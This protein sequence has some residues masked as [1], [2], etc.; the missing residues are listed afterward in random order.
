MSQLLRD[1]W[2]EA[3]ELA[4]ALVVEQLL[5]ADL[6]AQCRR[7]GLAWDADREVA[8]IDFLGRPYEIRSPTFDVVAGDRIAGDGSAADEVALVERILL[9]HYLNRADGTP[10]PGEW[11]AFAQIPGGDLYLRNFQARSADRI[12]RTFGDRPQALLDAAAPLGGEA[13]DFG[14]AAVVIQA[15]PRVRLLVVV[16]GGDDEFSATASVLFEA[17][18]THYLS[19]EDAIVMADRTATSLLRGRAR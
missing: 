2:R 16:H 18:A 17:N 11:I 8:K 5:T 3:W 4:L 9:L 19:T 15:L 13:A 1:S 6:E 12:A 14:D 7:A 10:P